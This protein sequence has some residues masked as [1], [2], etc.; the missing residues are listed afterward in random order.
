MNQLKNSFLVAVFIALPLMG[1]GKK[2]TSGVVV[3]KV[4]II[5]P[6]TGSA[7][8]YGQWA[9]HGVELAIA[10]TQGNVEYEFLDSGGDPKTAVTL[11]N[12]A[13]ADNRTIALWTVTSGDTMAVRDIATNSGVS[14]ITATATSPVITDGRKGIFRTIVNSRQETEALV[15]Y[16]VKKLAPKKVAILYINDAGGNA[17]L[18]EFRT[19]FKDAHI[20][21]VVA[22]PFEKNP[23]ELRTVVA[24]VLKP[25]PDTVVVTGYSAAMGAVVSNIRS[26]NKKVPILCNTGF[27]NPE[28]LS[29]SPDI[30]S[31]IYFSIAFVN[32]STSSPFDV[33]FKNRFGAKPNIYEVTAYDTARL[34]TEAVNKGANKDTLDSTLKNIQYSGENGSYRFTAKGNVLKDVLINK[35]S[36]GNV[37][38]DE[39]YSPTKE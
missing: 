19:F 8:V 27:N 6:M 11:A 7:A 16:A 15:Q 22:E 31:D 29:L 36:R 34:I 3:T 10:K 18:E 30:L 35:V 32:L 13:V 24:K 9:Q 20:E 26:L 37:T 39:K 25:E 21:I 33:E 14:L 38:P 4:A 23:Q 1:C 5:A 17:S 28:N 12:K 2:Q